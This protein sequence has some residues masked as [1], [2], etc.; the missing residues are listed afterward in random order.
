MGYVFEEKNQ[1]IYPVLL[2]SKI[3][4]LVK[5]KGGGRK[6]SFEGYFIPISFG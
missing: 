4:T 3:S 2:K 6:A 5:E 1:L